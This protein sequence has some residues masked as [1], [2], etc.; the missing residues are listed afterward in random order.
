MTLHGGLAM[1]RV[2]NRID[3]AVL[4]KIY[5]NSMEIRYIIDMLKCVY[6]DFGLI[7]NLK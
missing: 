3:K 1:L 5:V 2:Y 6:V 7:W 4:Y